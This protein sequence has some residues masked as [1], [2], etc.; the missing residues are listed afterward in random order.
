MGIQIK[1]PEIAISLLL[2]V[3]LCAL[4]LFINTTG[5]SGDSILHFLYSKYSF[6]HPSFFLN[7]WAK[8]VFVLLSSPFSQFGFK[9]II[10]FNCLLVSVTALLTYRTV[11]FFKLHNP[12][13]V[14]VIFLASPLFFKLIFSGLTEY[15]FAFIFI[16][17]VYLSC[18]QRYTLSALVVS[19]LPMIRSE[20]LLIVGLFA[21]FFLFSNRKFIPLFCLGTGHVLYALIGLICKGDFLWV[22]TQIPYTNLESPYGKG[23]LL[24][25]VHRLNYVIE[26]PIYA[27]LVLGLIFLALSL[28]KSS[29][30]KMSPLFTLLIGGSFF[31]FFIA[32]SAFWWLGTF[33][34]M[35][36]P[37]VLISVIPAVAIL[38]IYGL[39]CIVNLLK[40][41]LHQ[42]IALTAITLL[43][44]AFPFTNRKQGIV[45]NTQTFS[46][47]ENNLVVEEV[48]PWLNNNNLSPVNHLSY[49]TS[50]FVSLKLNIDHFDDKI[51]RDLNWL[52]V[53]PADKGS[54][55]IWDN[56][57]S[58]VE[59][60]MSL[61]AL[62]A[63]KNLKL[64][65]EFKRTDND[66]LIIFAVFTTQS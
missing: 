49:Y 16:L 7:H 42:N 62:K 39:Q 15:L 65:K 36:L 40:S 3:F 32:H 34:S 2:F 4:G 23:H 33:N 6:R 45:Y 11:V 17:S 57:Y 51:H 21:L 47:P 52:T 35:G 28:F 19:F 44:A 66:R 9:G 53:T 13:L 58:P 37:R 60:G 26:K 50:S 56:F 31:V 46:I 43:I 27:L 30:R 14:F 63:N 5:D 54:V 1:K 38:A 24:D 8:P 22:F 41:P 48:I 18:H 25:F 55:I 61:E 10:V 12:W 64:L 20:G 59:S 29:K